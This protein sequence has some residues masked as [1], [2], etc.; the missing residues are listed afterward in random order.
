MKKK[1]KK[2]KRAISDQDYHGITPKQ[3][4]QIDRILEK[5]WEN[6]LDNV[7]TDKDK[8]E[9]GFVL[10]GI[11]LSVEEQLNRF[12]ANFGLA[13]LSEDNTEE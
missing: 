13:A 1:N 8:T 5:A 2:S 11:L 4:K 7:L 9:K 3:E 10:P 6:I 12:A